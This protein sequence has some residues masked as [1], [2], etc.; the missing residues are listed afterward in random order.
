[1]M[2]SQ[3]TA[4]DEEFA[5]PPPGVPRPGRGALSNRASRYVPTHTLATDDG[6]GIDPELDAAPLET[7][8]LAD[9]TRELITRN[10]SPDIPFDRSIN[11]YK[12]CEH[13]CVYCFARPTHAY[14]DLSP[15]LDFETRLFYKTDVVQRLEAALCR[16]SY[17][18]RPIA[19]GTNTDPY[20]PIERRYRV[21]RQVLE[22]LLRARHPVTLVTKSHLVLDDIG[23]WRDLAQLKLAR[24]AVS[25][26]TLDRELKRK[27]EPRTASPT[28]RLRTIERL[29]SAGVPVGVMAAPVIPFVNDAELERILAA[30]KDAGATTA[31]YILLRLPL[32]VAD[33]FEEWL[34]AH[35][36]QARSRVLSVLRDTRGG[37]LYAARWGERMRGTGAFAEL[38]AAR[39]SNAT[40]KLGLSG[41]A[42]VS[43]LRTDLF[44]PPHAQ[45]SLF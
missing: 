29:A 14:L 32:E 5:G 20:Q 39:F 16:P 15:G 28:A 12:G 31:G 7:I 25:V 24:V 10:R 4:P 38:L 45:Q 42:G 2:E 35:Y 22:V 3:E 9:R 11:P 26:T 1:M 19:M 17:H 44:R 40:R 18:V 27:L 21:T 33:L 34:E 36:P 37:A 30:A 41:D 23:L 8:V 13:G 43:V 6:W